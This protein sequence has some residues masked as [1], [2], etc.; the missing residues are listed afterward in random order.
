MKIKLE[1]YNTLKNVILLSKDKINLYRQA[2]IKEGTAKDIEKRLRWD[3][4]WSIPDNIRTS[5]INQIYTYANDE[6][7]DT[8]LKKL[9][10]ELES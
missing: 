4:L 8:A 1:H 7:I 5:L 2:I 3:L 9:V 6:H 10:R